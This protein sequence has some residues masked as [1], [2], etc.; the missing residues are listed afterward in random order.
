MTFRQIEDKLVETLRAGGAFK[1]V[2]TYAGQLDGEIEKLPLRYPA[3]F[4]VY[5]GSEFGLVDE[6]IAFSVIVAA[7]NLRGN[8]AARKGTTGEQGAYQLIIDVLDALANQN[9]GLDIKRLLPLKSSPV[10]TSGPVSAYKMDFQTGFIRASETKI[11]C[12]ALNILE[13][14]TVGLSAGA[15]HADY[16]LYRLYDRN[17]GRTFKTASAETTEIKI[18]QGGAAPLPVDRL[19]IPAGHNLDGMALELKCSDDD[20]NYSSAVP[21]WAGTSGLIDKSWSALT[22]RYWKFII[23]SPEAAPELSELFLSRTYDWEKSPSLPAGPLDPAFNVRHDVTA[24]GQDRF[25]IH[26]EPK[27]RRLYKV[28]D[29]G[30]TQKANILALNDA[31]SG[32]CPFYLCDHE[33]IWIFGRLGAPLNLRELAPQTYGFDFDFI[34]ALP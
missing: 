18:D 14:S 22:K 10:G 20:S 31:W 34:E 17:I 11:K 33:G 16:P 26:G 3:A 24:G 19:I 6:T 5:G 4:V 30:E 8:E 1:S 7:K 23:A 27:R 9:L 13:T 12:C 29:C 2:E 25:M 15:A 21:P 32:A 28:P